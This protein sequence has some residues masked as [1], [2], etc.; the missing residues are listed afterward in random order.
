[1]RILLVEDD[2]QLGD[3]L[4]AALTLDNYA[5]D[6]ERDGANVAS[7]LDMGEYDLMILD[8][9]LPNVSGIEVLKDLRSSNNPLPV[10]ILSAKDAVS[11]RVL[12]LNTGADDYLTKP[13]A[14]D[15]LSARIRSL[16]RRRQES[17]ASR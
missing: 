11:D 7:M 15:E 3:S 13:F 2:Y 16:I 9:G 8:L 17:A 6:W 4:Q 5:V 14:M 1:M 10:L 12:G